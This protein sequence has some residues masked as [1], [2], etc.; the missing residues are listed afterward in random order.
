MIITELII[1]PIMILIII[2]WSMGLML[3]CLWPICMPECPPVGGVKGT[4]GQFSKFHVCFCGLGPGNLKFETV[5]TDKQHTCF[6]GFETLNF[7]FAI[8]NH[9]SWQYKHK[10]DNHQSNKGYAECF[11]LGGGFQKSRAWL[12]AC[13]LMNTCI[14]EQS[15]V[16]EVPRSHLEETPGTTT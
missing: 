10:I 5:R 6:L 11:P 8:W 7:K 4:Y 3:S 15:R 1:K 9:E 16:Q 13:A 12:F 2:H 14:Y